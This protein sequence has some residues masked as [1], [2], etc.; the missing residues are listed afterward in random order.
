M[1]KEKTYYKYRAFSSTT[2]ESLCEDTI[3]FANPSSFNDPLDCSP[4]IECNSTLDELRLI[5]SHLFKL[6]RKAEI[7]KNLKLSSI[8]LKNKDEFINEKIESEVKKMFAEF[9]YYATDPEYDVSQEKAE[10]QIFH[11]HIESEIKRYYSRGVSCFSSQF[12]NPLLWSHYGDQHKGICIGYSTNRLPRP[13]LKEVIYGGSRTIK[14]STILKAFVLNDPEA[15]SL[16]DNDVLLKKAKEWRYEK[17]SRLI[18]TQGI[19]DSPLLL[20][21]ITFG[22]RCTD[23]IKHTLIKSLENRKSSIQYFEMYTKRD[24][25]LLKRKKFDGWYNHYPITAASGIE[26]FGDDELSV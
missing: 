1:K 9:S 23:V 21:E 12:S 13:E 20:T 11:S 16:L 17:E 6:R 14:S 24:S 19:Q 22:L 8:N 15:K 18:G 26:I 7:E 2:L 3:Y 4:S 25:Y 10:E 5:Y